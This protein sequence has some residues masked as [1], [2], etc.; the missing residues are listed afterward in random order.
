[1]IKRIFIPSVSFLLL[2]SSSSFAEIEGD[3]VQVRA[4]SPKL[5]ET[6]PGRIVSTS[7][8]VSSHSE[9]EEEFMEELILPAGWQKVAAKDFPLRLKPQERQISVVAFLVPLTSPAGHYLVRY[10]LRNQRDYSVTD[11]DTISV[12]VLPVGK[13]EL[14]VEDKPERV[15]AGQGYQ[16]GLRLVNRGNYKIS[17]RLQIKSNPEY[18]VRMEPSEIALEAGNSQTIRLDVKT[19]EKIKQ[20]KR[21]ILEIKAEPEE[22]GND[23]VSVTQ[24]ISVEIIPPVTENPDLYHALPSQVSL[25][26]AGE[27]KGGDFQVEF[28]GLGAL[29][30]EGKRKIDFLFRGPDIQDKS[31]WGKRDELKVSFLSR[32]LDLHLGDRSYLLSPLT[33]R[34]SYGRGIEVDIR[35]GKFGW[36]ASFWENRWGTPKTSK[37]GTY[38]SYEPNAKLN[39]KGNFLVKG[40]KRPFSFRDYEARIYSLQTGFKP[41]KKTQLN[42]ECG[43]SQS[44]KEGGSNDLA[45][46]INLAGLVFNQIRY[47]LERA[48]A[49]PEYFGYLNDTDYKNGTLSFPI[50]R[51]LR[52]GLF[53]RAYENN[54][55]FDSTKGTANREKTYQATVSYSFASGTQISLDYNNL[56]REDL[57]LPVDYNYKETAVKLR[58]TES[59][60]KFSLS[61]DVERGRFEDK[62]K[63]AKSDNLE[64]YSFYANF[65]PGYGHSYSLYVRIGHSSFTGSPE[66][67]K[68][69]G[70]SSFWRIRNKI[71][72]SLNYRWDESG[73]DRRKQNNLF[74]TISYNFSRDHILVFKSQW[75]ASEKGNG[76][77][78][79][80]SLAYNVPLK[81][82]LSKKNSTGVIKGAI[83]DR[84]GSGKIPVPKVILTTPG[85]TAITDDHG[86]F[87]FPSLEP[88]TYFLQMERNSIGFDRIPLERFPLAIEVRD[89]KTAE[90]EIGVVRSCRISGRIKVFS[91]APDKKQD[92]VQKNSDDSLL[93]I[94]P[95]EEENLVKRLGNTLVE[96][97]DGKENL[98]QLTDQNGGFGFEDIRPGNWI[99][100]VHD[101]DLSS[102]Y[103]LEQKEFQIELEPGEKKEV[104]VRVL[105]RLRPI[106]IM[107]EGEIRN[108]R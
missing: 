97:S 101:E 22:P 32:R 5:E 31:R 8:L 51:Q 94:G 87:I 20:R 68:S 92:D 36:G 84:D 10:S 75:S 56:F 64:R 105:P 35:P 37:V 50:Y 47:S 71:S 43:F 62:I 78:F 25:V 72:L 40:M 69:I 13:L 2:L 49:G 74:S 16:I 46:Q 41:D 104:M 88:G 26:Y 17:V 66:R 21:Q 7:F 85:A 80:F 28:S 53:Y 58:M 83:Y 45:F 67:T 102:R 42:V 30:K 65:A 82:P 89:G 77:D 1:M 108:K 55:D 99:L 59:L 79:S 91:S 63:A 9:S 15:L 3:A 103:Y 106:Q 90:I 6:K 19:D 27:E 48:F 81:I 4:S 38:L 57:V 100:K 34:Q 23:A 107:E 61:T 39:L 24:T 86:E 54:L 76:E 93:W 44:E 18:P 73:P 33:E 98:R 96:L 29:D 95:S 11:S 70:A 14:A 60:S 52:G 12:V